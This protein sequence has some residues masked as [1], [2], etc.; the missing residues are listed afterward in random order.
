MRRARWI[1]HD[2]PTRDRP[3]RNALSSNTAPHLPVLDGQRL[4]RRGLGRLL[5]RRHQNLLPAAR[6]GRPRR[7]PRPLDNGLGACLLGA[8]R[9]LPRR[10]VR[11][12]GVDRLDDHRLG[13]PPRLQRADA[14]SGEQ[15]RAG[16]VPDQVA[17]VGHLLALLGFAAA[18]A[19]EPQQLESEQ[20]R[21]SNDRRRS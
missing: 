17:D 10:A 6:E 2:S 7:V 14:E 11:R 15:G 16:Q 5:R 19:D 18:T 8:R 21:V 9:R 1:S 4:Q 3:D 12:L 20:Q 13:R